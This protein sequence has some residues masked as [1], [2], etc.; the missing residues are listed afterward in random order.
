MAKTQVAPMAAT[1][2]PPPEPR[3]RRGKDDDIRSAARAI[4]ER[5]GTDR[6]RGRHD[7]DRSDRRQRDEGE[8]PAERRRAERR[9]SRTRFGRDEERPAKRQARD[10]DDE[11]DDPDEND[12]EYDDDDP[13][14]GQDPDSD[15][16]ADD[17]EAEDDR[18]DDRRRRHDRE[19]DDD[20]DTDP[21]AR[22]ERQRRKYAREPRRER[23]REDERPATRGKDKEERPDPLEFTSLDDKALADIGKDLDDG[24][25]FEAFKAFNSQVGGIRDT[26]K[27]LRSFAQEQFRRQLAQDNASAVDFFRK[28]AKDGH[29]RF[30][31]RD[32]RNLSEYQDGNR[33]A[34]LTEAGK[35]Q[36]RAF[37]AMD[38]VSWND[39]MQ[40]AHDEIAGG[41]QRS[42]R[43]K[44]DAGD[45]Q[46]RL[47]DNDRF[48]IEPANSGGEY[49]KPA[50]RNGR[51][52]T[53]DAAQHIEKFHRDRGVRL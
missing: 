4:E 31:G 39:A 38:Y 11:F 8:S 2:T 22:F 29:Q 34:V 12:P 32:A 16:D 25:A 47:R 51:D 19:D 1:G 40:M 35:I 5:S 44:V 28:M 21:D 10:D 13:E 9:D 27:M 6:G 14:E 18:D 20:D 45:R 15:P 50:N 24:P 53:D 42:K 52:D 41:E 3:T 46:S 43:R 30:Y 36:K 23:E 26:L 48:D 37:R 17:D 49:R 33:A 7:D